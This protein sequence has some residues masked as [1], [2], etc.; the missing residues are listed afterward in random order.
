MDLAKKTTS[1]KDKTVNLETPEVEILNEAAEVIDEA[2]NSA[3]ADA[4]CELDVLKAQSAEY[5]DKMQRTLA[6]F[7]NF[8]KR[9]ATEKASMYDN[10][11]RDTVLA[12]LPA[13]DNFERALNA[14]T[15]KDDAF[16]K[17]V[18]MI[19]KHMLGL[20][21]G[22]GIEVIDAVGKPFD[23]NMHAGVAHVE[24]EQYGENEIIEEMMKGYTH[25][26]KVI[27]CSMVKVAN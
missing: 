1:K 7:D 25:K 18:D 21:D 24:D 23:P 9:T 14:A 3:E 11:V 6:E 8:R 22:L 16:V 2:T 20:L 15:D 27:R 4:P 5:L 13:I 12:L 26:G 19:Y 17:G 10:G